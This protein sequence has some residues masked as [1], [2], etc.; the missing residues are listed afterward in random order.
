ME[1]RERL[2]VREVMNTSGYND[3]RQIKLSSQLGV[4]ESFESLKLYAEL[5]RCM[6]Y[7]QK[8]QSFVKIFQSSL[9][10]QESHQPPGVH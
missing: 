2:L 10:L 9:W 4:Q 6:F 3:L 5:G 7:G 1:S 8:I